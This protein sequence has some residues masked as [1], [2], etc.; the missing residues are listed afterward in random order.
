MTQHE[1]SYLHY[2]EVLQTGAVISQQTR[3]LADGRARELRFSDT[4]YEIYSPLFDL[5][6]KG[7]IVL[8]PFQAALHQLITGTKQRPLKLASRCLS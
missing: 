5:Y 7:S 6:T 4:S 2:R 1:L 8:I 3:M